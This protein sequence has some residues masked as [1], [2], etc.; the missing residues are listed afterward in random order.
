MLDLAQIEEL[1]HFSTEKKE[2]VIEQKEKNNRRIESICRHVEEIVQ[3][4]Y[5]D[6]K[7]IPNAIEYLGKKYSTVENSD[8]EI[9]IAEIASFLSVIESPEID[10]ASKAGLA[11]VY[12]FKTYRRLTTACGLSPLKSFSRLANMKKLAENFLIGNLNTIVYKEDLNEQIAFF[13]ELLQHYENINNE[14]FFVYV[15]RYDLKTKKRRKN[16]FL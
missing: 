12:E 7:G 3:T 16:I 6:G 9:A 11:H 4:I 15:L 10:L 8:I 5:R 2:S 14:T 13:K 1:F